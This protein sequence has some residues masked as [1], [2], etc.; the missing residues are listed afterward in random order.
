MSFVLASAAAAAASR[1]LPPGFL[2]PLD[3]ASP[4]LPLAPTSAFEDNGGGGGTPDDDARPPDA[5]EAPADIV[6]AVEGPPVEIDDAS[7]AP[8]APTSAFEDDGG[9]GGA[10]ED[11]TGPPDAEEA[12]ADIVA[13]VEG[14]P[15]EAEVADGCDLVE[16]WAEGEEEEDGE[17]DEDEEGDEEDEGNLSLSA[18]RPAARS[19]PRSPF[20][21]SSAL[22]AVPKEAPPSLEP[23]AVGAAPAPELAVGRTAPAPLP[24][25]WAPPP[26]AERAL[27]I[28]YKAC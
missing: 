11:D 7:T 24:L 5:E 20:P 4:P 23:R 8:L 14:P 25:P 13:A 28:L 2:D 26:P 18:A 16:V 3:V 9:G 6:A 21:S 15:V 17:E 12:P 10:P 1:V 22:T 19:P 27:L